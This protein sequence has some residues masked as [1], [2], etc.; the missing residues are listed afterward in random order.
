M[1]LLP[2]VLTGCFLIEGPTPETPPRETPE[3]EANPEFVAGGTAEENLPFF[4]HVLTE[5]ADGDATVTGENVVDAVSD[6][7]FDRDDMQVS[8]DR[9]KTSLVADN[10]FVAVRS[11]KDCLVG[12]V[13]TEK[14]E[15][16]A[17]VMPVVG[18]DGG[19]CLIGETR[20]IDW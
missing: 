20:D 8:F 7:G 1:A 17:E 10:I 2:F 4:R 9:T 3:A 12:Q 5:F 14:R 11:G 18:P 15:V 16:A 19:T 6:G 13:T